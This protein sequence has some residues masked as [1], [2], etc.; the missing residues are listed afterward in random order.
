MV[1]VGAQYLLM[2]I[3]TKYLLWSDTTVLIVSISLFPFV[4]PLGLYNNDRRAE[5]RRS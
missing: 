5:N 1:G 2:P 3:M 4:L